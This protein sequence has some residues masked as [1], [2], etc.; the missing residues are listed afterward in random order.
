[1]EWDV[2]R[3]D[4]LDFRVLGPV[5]VHDHRSGT[6]I[7]P[8]GAKQRALLAALVVRAGEVLSAERLID[9]LWGD[10]PPAGAANALQAHVARL[11]RLLA[12]A[13]EGDPGQ[14]LITTHPLGY[15]LRLGSARTD[16]QRFTRLSAQGRAAVVA[17]P[18]HAADLLDRALALWRGPALE[19]SGRGQI[20]AREAERL[21]QS[22]LTALET[23][24]EAK[25]RGAR[26]AEV[27]GE[28]ER[29]TAAHPTRERFY[30]LLMLALYR[31]GRR[32]EA[33]GVY[34]RAR[35]R[36]M[37]EIGIGPGPALRDRMES[38]LLRE[39]GLDSAGPPAATGADAAAL[40]LGGEIARLRARIDAIGREQDEL[41]RRFTL[42]S[43]GAREVPSGL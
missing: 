30:D 1:M 2:S 32:S 22:R 29:L 34:E 16:A 42:L 23:C 4:G 8:S 33:L 24:Y 36:L 43:E 38:I 7:T 6:R 17:D 3:S 19:G 14:A 13:G 31:C 37:S 41:V 25:L 27:T 5:E 21:E 20:C 15:L 26:H 9:E 40:D 12:P 11:R 35:Q 39:P 28:L 18:A 10:R